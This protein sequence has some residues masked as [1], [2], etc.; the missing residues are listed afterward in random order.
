MRDA[1]NCLQSIAV[2]IQEPAGITLSGSITDL[3][4][5]GDNSGA[6][7]LSV[8]GGTPPFVYSW[9]NGASTQD[10]SGLAAGTYSVIV[11]DANGCSRETAFTLSEPPALTLSCTPS[12]IS[13]IN[14][15]DGS[16]LLNWEGGT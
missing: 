8:G 11:S 2:S 1:N 9:S 14:G 4:C 15:N 3:L 12:P 5:N 16:I 10:L 13:T 6:I 7:D